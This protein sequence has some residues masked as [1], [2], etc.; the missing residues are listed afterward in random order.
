MLN[1]SKIIIKICYG[2]LLLS[3][4]AFTDIDLSNSNLTLTKS[5]TETSSQTTTFTPKN[6]WKPYF[7]WVGNFQT[8]ESVFAEVNIGIG[9]LYF[10]D[11]QANLGNKPTSLFSQI[12]SV[13]DKQDLSYS[14][15]PLFEYIV[16]YRFTNWLKF[17][18]SYQN[19]SNIYLQTRTLLNTSGTDST[20][21]VQ[22][23]ADVQLNSIIGKFYFELPWPMLIKTLAF[24]PYIAGGPG[25]SWQSWSNITDRIFQLSSVTFLGTDVP[26]RQKTVANVCAMIDAGLR[27]HGAY[28]NSNF[29]MTAGC[30][31]NYWGQTR[32]L[33]KLEQQGSFKRGLIGPFNIKNLYSFAPYIGLHWDFPVEKGATIAGRSTHT[34][35]IFF[36]SPKSVYK[37]PCVTAQVN[38][39]PTFLYFSGLRGNLAGQPSSLFFGSGPSIPLNRRLSYIKSPLVECIL[40]YRLNRWLEM[41]I[42]Y[43]YLNET[44]ISSRWFAGRGPDA[45][46]SAQSQFQSYLNLNAFMAKF[47]ADLITGVVQSMAWTPFISVGVGPSWQ[48]WTDVEIERTAVIGGTFRNDFLYLRDAIIA[49]ASW[50][51]DAGIKIRNASPDFVFSFVAGCKYSQWGQVRNIGKLSKQNGLH[52]GLV[53]PICVKMMYSFTP[54]LGMQWDFPVSYCYKIGNKS[55]N[56][57]VP[58][59]TKAKNIQKR[60]SLMTQVNIGPGILFFDQINGNFGG[61]PAANFIQHGS[62]PFQ[63]SLRY[64]ITP[65]YEFVLGYRFFQWFKSAIAYQTQKSLFFSTKPI[66]GKGAMTE[67]GDPIDSA[68]NQFRAHLTLDSFMLKFYFELPLPL[69]FKGYA[70]SPYIAASNGV[71]W[72]SWTNM[73]VNRILDAPSTIGLSS[74]NQAIRQKIIANYVWMAE[75]GFRVRN[76][77]P[78]FPFSG[79]FGCKYIQWGQTRNIGKLSQQANNQRLGITKPFRIKVLGSITPYVGLQWNF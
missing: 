25:V 31:Y 67:D 50:M 30:K 43:L 28:P 61:V 42:S 46:E 33:G 3:T 54:Y 36:V 27:I 2:C 1:R 69:V 72:Q 41:G 34:S 16:G 29:S 38:I 17:A 68:K 37:Q 44:M 40:G 6:R 73:R 74:M 57:W 21:R 78:N 65:V 9:F 19:Q 10:S 15:T 66:P 23:G 14:K 70:I 18:L 11:V 35:E 60:F 59:I 45:F 56:T 58:F 13:P 63:G 64:N 76:A 48:S 32:N 24:S 39:G 22:F 71:G 20:A 4:F 12:G 77:T 7:P 47:S 5:T 53:Q 8:K 26:Y 51:A 49:N 62:S 79:V 52:M 75:G 55:I